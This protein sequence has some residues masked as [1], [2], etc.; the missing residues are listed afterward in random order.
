MAKRLAPT[1][2][3]E[4]EDQRLARAAAQKIAAGGR[5]TRD[6]AAGLRRV[7]KRQEETD[8]WAYYATIPKRH[9]LEMS[10]RQAK[11]V[12]EQAAL[13][14]IP[15]SGRTVDAGAVF[16]WIHDFLAKHK[17]VIRAAGG[18]DPLMIGGDSQGLERYR[19]ARAEMAE[20]ELDER[21]KIMMR[22][23]DV[24]EGLEMVAGIL[25]RAGG[26]LQ[27]E[28]GAG[29]LQIMHE[30]LDDADRKVRELFGSGEEVE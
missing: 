30:A 19:L 16:R 2:A 25:R 29:A 9:Y 23:A 21:R 5:P 7:R 28:F 10:G 12:N 22:K 27:R 11:V 14:G 18:D 15:C 24:Y 26:R 17:N 20:Y 13:H 8:R 4:K 1:T 3:A 6:E